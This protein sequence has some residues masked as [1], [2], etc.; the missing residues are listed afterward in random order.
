MVNLQE[1]KNVYLIDGVQ[2]RKNSTNFNNLKGMVL[3]EEFKNCVHPS[4]KN[5]ITELK[6]QSLQKASEIADKFFL[7]HKHIFQKCSQG[8]T[9]KRNF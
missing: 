3:L 4:I 1:R 5:H 2:V 9:C 8:L 6:T 7:T